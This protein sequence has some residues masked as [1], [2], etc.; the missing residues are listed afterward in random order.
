MK[1]IFK[2]VKVHNFLSFGDEEFNFDELHGLTRVKG[3]NFDIP[4]QINGSGKSAV[5]NSLVYGLYGELPFK[6]KN[7]NICNRYLKDKNASVTV[8][9]TVSRKDY[10]VV[11]GMKG[12]QSY[13]ELYEATESGDYENIT[14][15]TIAE[16]RKYIEKDILHCDLNLFMRTIYLN[17]DQNYNF[18]NLK[19]ADRKDFIDKLFD[20]SIFGDMYATIHRDVL[21]MEKD[22]AAFQ[23]RLIILNK[24]ADEYKTKGKEFDENSVLK[25]NEIEK[26]LDETKKILEKKKASAVK[27][28]TEIESKFN[29]AI[30][31]LTET[32][33]ELK[34]KRSLTSK[35]KETISNSIKMYKSMIADKQKIIDKHSELKSRLCKDC[36][37]ILSKYY[38]LDKYQKEIDS[39]NG[40]ISEESKKDSDIAEKISDIDSKV[41]EYTKK[42]E[43]LNEK[44]EQTNSEYDREQN[45]IRNLELCCNSYETQLNNTKSQTNPY[46]ELS[47]DNE[48]KIETESAELE[49]ISD[50]YRYAKKSQDVVDQ[51]NLKRFIIHDLVGLLNNKIKFYLHKLGA[52]YDIV[53]D[54]DMKYDFITPVKSGV[55]F[56]NFSLGERAR[57]SIATCFAFRDFLSTR[58]RITSNILILDEFFDSNVDPLAIENTMD[59]LK[60]FV[61]NTKQKIYVV[62]HRLEVSDDSFN[63]IIQVEKK[64][65]VSKIR[66]LG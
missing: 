47:K 39:L 30:E 19:Q 43:V 21:R 16:T 13:C 55:E 45:E 8:F 59:I 26:K 36:K 4:N 5:M 44:L 2:T 48:R 64:N 54:D 50:T 56:N 61:R 12:K 60:T 10:K 37:P 11:S 52:N 29:S 46:I 7:E 25:V 15:S 1:L 6:L 34:T 38:N 41:K 35:E 40:K 42:L 20:I 58:S 65:N 17:S 51:E 23:N 3:K 66:K 18:Y 33:R 62:S 22:I 24:N 31:K 57:I 32:I 28:N 53:F 27:K 9:F 14:R 63:H 49:K